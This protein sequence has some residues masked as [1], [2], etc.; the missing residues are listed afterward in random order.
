MARII[1]IH[2]YGYTI[3]EGVRQ[4]QGSSTL[5]GIRFVTKGDNYPLYEKI[6]E[7]MAS[8]WVNENDSSKYYGWG[9][10]DYTVAGRTYTTYYNGFVIAH[11]RPYADGSDNRISVLYFQCV[12][13]TALTREERLA[14]ND[15]DNPNIYVKVVR[16]VNEEGRDY[17]KFFWKNSN[18]DTYNYY[19][20]TSYGDASI[21]I[22]GAFNSTIDGD[23]T[24]LLALN[25]LY[26]P[27][28]YGDGSGS[29]Y[30]GVL[31][32]V[33]QSSSLGNVAVSY[34]EILES[35]TFDYSIVDSGSA[36]TSGFLRL[37]QLGTI[38]KDLNNYDSN[39]DEPIPPT[40]ERNPYEDDY[41]EGGGGDGDYTDTSDDI[42]ID[43]LP[44]V[45]ALS[46]G[47]TRIYNP[48]ES[49][50]QSFCAWLFSSD[51]L[52][53]VSRLINNPID[54][55]LSVMLAPYTPAG[56][57][58]Q[59]ISMGGVTSQVSSKRVTNQYT[60]LDCGTV[61]LKEFWAKFY[62]Y[63][64]YTSVSIYLPFIGIRQLDVDDVMASTVTL[65]YHVDVLTGACV[66]IVHVDNVRAL[67]GAVY[68]FEG[69]CHVSI[70]LTGTNY[71]NMY[72]SLVRGAVGAVGNIVAGNPIG[73]VNTALDVI[74]S[75]KVNV[76]HAGNL[77]GNAGI[78]SNY[79]PFLI[80]SR[81]SQSLPQDFKTFKGFVS[82]VTKTLDEIEGYTE[83][84]YINVDGISATE[85]EK[86]MIVNLLKSGVIF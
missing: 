4:T 60:E 23:G 38:P 55:L 13:G 51:F 30:G 19:R 32:R 74:E 80:V 86:D 3:S 64:P 85:S 65:K 33:M 73:L 62:D 20:A 2:G 59:L 70:P 1:D 25:T 45:S 67:N 39:Y 21:P 53:N 36:T 15:W 28:I 57:S 56:V 63:A 42:P 84:A 48:S 27:F 9:K 35:Q 49:E 71:S 34:S 7:F 6:R 79:T 18:M 46:T 5:N 44:S 24:G 77:S 66:A 75:S 16:Y 69:N 78:L 50:M 52:T 29:Y 17:K 68:Y 11:T 83:V 10:Y 41:N 76:E 8:E 14:K 47:Y 72:M 31:G 37:Y 26:M 61:E 43:G 54:Y 22:F 58:G 82:N 81:P 12:S 40:P